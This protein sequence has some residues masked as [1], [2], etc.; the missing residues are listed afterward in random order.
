ML[1]TPIEI[2][3]EKKYI[4][5]EVYNLNKNR[6]IVELSVFSHIVFSHALGS[7]GKIG[8]GDFQGKNF[9]WADN[10]KET[11]EIN[12]ERKSKLMVLTFSNN[13]HFSI[14]GFSNKAIRN[15]SI[16]I[17]QSRTLHIKGLAMFGGGEVKTY[18]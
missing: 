5:L 16:V 10:Q 18:L 13:K 1:P 8:D 14:G 15:P 11:V 3:I 7:D 12:P 17:D 6:K 2:D 4:G 9:V